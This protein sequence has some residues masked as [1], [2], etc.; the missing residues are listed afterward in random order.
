MNIWFTSDTHFCHNKPF[1]YTPRNAE[2]TEEMSEAIVEHWNNLVAVDDIVYFLGD[3]ALND[4][5]AA[6]EYIKQLNGTIIWFLGNHDTFKRV[7][8][9]LDKCNNIK[10]HRD[11]Y[12]TTLKLN[13]RGQDLNFYVSHYPTLTAN[14]D[15]KHFSRHVFSLHGHTHQSDNWMDPQ[16]PF[17][18]HVGLDSHNLAPVH[19]EEVVADIRNR[20]NE[21]G[22]NTPMLNAD[23]ILTIPTGVK[24]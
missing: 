13:V 2:S 17:L 4:T 3:I 18:Y 22:K 20:W 10:L 6:I 16:N 12:A 11:R 7:Q 21:L 5:T 23:N 15:D 1:I 19:I 8:E 9:V 14:F 24:L